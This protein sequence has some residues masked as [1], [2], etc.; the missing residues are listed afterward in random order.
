MSESQ[1]LNDGNV[2]NS[3]FDQDRVNNIDR[4]QFRQQNPTVLSSEN[5]IYLAGRN[6]IGSW[7]FFVIILPFF[8]VMYM[9]RYV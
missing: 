3:R 1:V 2:N 9:D 7:S 8:Y 6:I 5:S 4:R